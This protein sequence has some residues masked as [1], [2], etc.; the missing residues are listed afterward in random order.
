VIIDDPEFNI[1]QASFDV[2]SYN[3]DNHTNANYRTDGILVDNKYIKIA[4]SG[5][6]DNSQ[7]WEYYNSFKAEKLIRNISGARII[8]F[9]INSNNLETLDQDKNPDR[10]YLFFNEN[11]LKGQKKR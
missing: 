9:L 11:Y 7:A 1:N 2:I 10:Y 6:A 8:T 3:I 4:V 5:F